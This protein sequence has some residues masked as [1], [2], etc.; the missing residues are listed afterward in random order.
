MAGR[1]SAIGPGNN[2]AGD[3]YGLFISSGS[4]SSEYPLIVSQQPGKMSCIV[5]GRS[6]WRARL[7]L[8]ANWRDFEGPWFNA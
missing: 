5:G 7:R 1:P 6:P 3:G 2:A 4:F 8:Y